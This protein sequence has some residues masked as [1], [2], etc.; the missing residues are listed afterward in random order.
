MTSNDTYRVLG[1]RPAR[2]DAV[3]KVT[4]KAIF[5]AD[6]DLPGMLYAKMLR[7]PHAHARIRSVDTRRAEALPGVHAVVTARNIPRVAERMAA[8][9][10][11]GIQ[12]KYRCD[13]FLASDKVLYEGHAIAAVAATSPHIAEEAANLIQ[14]E[15]EVL[16]PVMDV[17]Q[18]M[19]EDAPLLHENLRTRSLGP[20]D[21]RP[22]NVASHFQEV[23]GDPA[24]G[25]AQADVIVEREF[26]TATVHQG[27]LEAHSA[28]AQW[29]ADGTLTLWSS[30]QGAFAVR[31]Q[32]VDIL[33]LPLAKIRVIPTEVGGGFGGKNRTYVEPVVALLAQLAGRPVK[34][35][36]TRAEVLLSSGPTSGTFMR[37]KMGA[38]H[39]GRITAAQAELYFEAG[40][41]PGSPVGTG[42]GCIFASYDI[43]N[44]QIDGYDIVVNK[45]R[46]GD[47]RGPGATQ[48]T[49]ASEQIVDELAQRLDMDPL[50]FRLLN[51]AKEGTQCIDGSVHQSIG[52]Y[53]VMQAARAHEHYRAPL[54][55]KNCGRGVAMGYWGNWGSHSSCTLSVNADGSLVLLSGS[56]D[57]SGTRTS[58]AMQVAEVLGV[59]VDQIRSNVGDTDSV[60]F[61]DLSGG[62]RTTFATGRAAIEA[63]ED[64]L[65]QMGERAALLWDVPVE[66][67][68]YDKTAFVTSQ[69]PAKRMSFRELA[70]Q[71][72]NTGGPI[73]GRG[74]VDAQGWGGAFGCHIADVE[75]DPETGKVKLLRYTVVQDVG[76]AIHPSFVEGQM[77]GGAAQGIGWALWE[78]YCYDDRGHMLNPGLMDY[79]QPTALD[80]PF[81]ETVI[82]EV[83]GPNHP[84][85]VRG[86]GEV[87]IV[88]PPAALANAIARAIGQRMDQLPMT[89]ERILR[90]MGVI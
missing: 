81:I 20:D 62:S 90:T 9:G 25:F 4:G 69:D 51:A 29:R 79:K 16:P 17:H 48:T 34:M 3:D 8:L 88:P 44:G 14:V 42:A 75:I 37:V 78:G 66:T 60:G 40:A 32:T 15:Y 5:G 30:T 43:P 45:P 67:V 83:P 6:I 58:I 76:K 85:G 1:T 63:T 80:L 86:V 11:A 87:P 24:Q 56:V 26:A 35:V 41:Y 28:T 73:T 54:P 22:S 13:N 47:Y 49:F 82:V 10:E 23:L 89:P 70:A 68:S 38:T 19:R 27:Y 77:Q 84:F 2:P 18:A 71:L 12:F 21:E 65:A 36:M 50:E 61:T 39:Q 33:D 55:G 72:N 59:N 53:E 7:S 31:D 46:T 52:A 57:L 74:N 64:V